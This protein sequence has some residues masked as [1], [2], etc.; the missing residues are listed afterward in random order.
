MTLRFL[1]QVKEARGNNEAR[2]AYT[3][4]LSAYERQAQEQGASTCWCFLRK[5]AALEP[6]KFRRELFS[7]RAERHPRFKVLAPCVRSPPAVALSLSRLF[8]DA[9]FHRRTL[10][11]PHTTE[12][13]LQESES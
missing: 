13:S 12:S 5:R 11:I 4:E 9:Y 7:A 2:N 6:N 3:E 8:P 10:P 1:R